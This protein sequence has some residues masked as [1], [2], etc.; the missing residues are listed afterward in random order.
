MRAILD[1][2]ARVVPHWRTHLDHLHRFFPVGLLTGP[3]KFLFDALAGF[4]NTYQDARL[5]CPMANAGASLS[6]LLLAERE[7]TNAGRVG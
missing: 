1:G 4:S 6:H 3:A 7:R 5:L 2:A